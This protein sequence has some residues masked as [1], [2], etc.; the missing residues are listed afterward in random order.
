MNRVRFMVIGLIGWGSLTLP[1]STAAQR[2]GE[3]VV[4]PTNWNAFAS[5]GLSTYGRFLLQRP[6]NAIAAA[7]E[8]ALRGEGGFN[9]GGGVGVDVMSRVGIRVSYAFGS[10]ELAFR[11]DTGNG[12][13]RL[14]AEDL[15][16]MKQHVA[17]AEVVRYMVSPRR[18]I[19]PYGSAGFVGT[20]WMLDDDVA[21]LDDTGGRTQFRFGAVGS[22]GVQLHAND[23]FD[24]RLEAASM[25]VRNP[26]AGSESFRALGGTTIDEPTRVSRTDFRLSAVY[27]FGRGGVSSRTADR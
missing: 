22:L 23:H 8:A 5:G 17:A 3:E 20:W 13:E 6:S 1:N 15:G 7:N 2:D 10:M 18:A 27:N 12:S 25:S 14:D 19:V 21:R 9:V 26:F 24:V 4:R 16:T 11:D